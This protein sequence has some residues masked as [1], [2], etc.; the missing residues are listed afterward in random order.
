M[1]TSDDARALP[2]E[3]LPFRLTERQ[4]LQG[5]LLL[6]IGSGC[7][8][9]L[10][11]FSL[12]PWAI[13]AAAAG[14]G[15][16]ALVFS[17]PFWALFLLFVLFFLPF[18][19]GNLTVAQICGLVT[20]VVGFV[21]HIYRRRPI[22]VGPYFVPMLCFAG[23]LSLSFL[24]AR[25]DELVWMGCRRFLTNLLVYLLTL[26]LTD[27]IPRLRNLLDA[28]LLACVCN[29]LYGVYAA[30]SSGETLERGS[31]FVGNANHLGFLCALAIPI[32]FFRYV[33]GRGVWRR[34]FYLAL[35]GLLLAGII[36]SAS[37]GAILSLL[38]GLATCA[39]QLRRRV[40]LLVP[41]VLVFLALL[42]IAPEVFRKRVSNL[43]EDVERSVVLDPSTKLTSRGYLHKAGVRAWK[44][45]P[46]WG[47]GTGNFGRYFAT[48]NYNPGWAR[49]VVIPQHNVYL[50]VLVENGLVGF[51]IFS[52]IL[53]HFARELMSLMLSTAHLPVSEIRTVAQGLVGSAAV[54]AIMG[55]SMDFLFTHELYILLALSHLAC[56]YVEPGGA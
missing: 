27:S 54:L 56:R 8:L 16:L 29:G 36:A 46:I 24:Y 33:D 45:H 14:V 37:R 47:V 9:A 3:V 1:R 6:G 43:G 2:R 13:L 35:C 51:V 20:I 44:D 42:P 31:G 52:F 41:V 26:F 19:L 49:G 53:W 18:D 21:S 10:L 11:V 39:I 23:V 34:A 25:Y 22:A 50:R 40:L 32:A 15:G 5:L 38:A 30:Y 28:L 7:A 48:S 12:P 17:Y 4:I 55:L